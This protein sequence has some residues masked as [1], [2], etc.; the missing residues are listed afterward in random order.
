MHVRQPF[1]DLQICLDAGS[2]KLAVRPHR[3][4]QEKV[5]GAGREDGGRQAVEVAVNRLELRILEVVAM[6]VKLCD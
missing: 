3:V 6:R 2:A 5:A 4:G 1:V